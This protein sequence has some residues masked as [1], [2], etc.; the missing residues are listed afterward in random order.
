MLVVANQRTTTTFKS[1]EINAVVAEI[2]TMWTNLA[3]DAQPGDASVRKY[4]EPQVRDHRII[5]DGDKVMGIT[6]K[7][8]TLDQRPPVSLDG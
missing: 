8:G 6:T 4:I 1:E 5:R 2:R 7:F 3:V